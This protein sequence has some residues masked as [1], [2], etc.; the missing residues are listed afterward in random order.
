[1]VPYIEHTLLLPKSVTENKINSPLCTQ[2]GGV[3]SMLEFYGWVGQ[4]TFAF[5]IN[6]IQD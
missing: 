4:S 2:R 5:K 1:M 6:E 3:V